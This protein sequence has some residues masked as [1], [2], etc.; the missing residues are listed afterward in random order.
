M[1]LRVPDARPAPASASTRSAPSGRPAPNRAHRNDIQGL[2][3]LAVGLVVCYHIWPNA[4][5]GGFIGV[6]VFFVISGYLIIGSLAREA[7]GGKIQLLRF[8]SRR[9]KRLLPA[10]GAVLVATM[11]ATVLILPQSRWQSVSRD[12][13]A[14]GLNIQNWNQAFFSTSYEGATA[15]VSPLQHF[16][17]L[18]VEEQFYLVAPVI[19]LS[20][21]WLARKRLRGGARTFKLLALGVLGSLTLASFTHSVLFSAASPDLA[22]FFTTTRVWELTLGGMVALAARPAGVR[23]ALSALLGWFGLLLVLGS[24][25]AFSTAMPFPGWIALFPVTGAIFLLLSGAS[26]QPRRGLSPAW[27]QSLGP[28]R[29][30]GDISYSLYLWHWPVI[31]FSVFLLGPNPGWL[32]GS[33]VIAASIALAAVSTRYI[34]QPVRNF[35]PGRSRSHGRRRAVTPG[36]GRI[37]ALG[38]LLTL[39]PIGLAAVPYQAMELKERSLTAELDLDTYPGAMALHGFGPRD[40]PDMPVRPDPAIAAADQPDAPEECRNSYDPAKVDYQDC[41]FG[42]GAAERSI[43]LVGDSHSA[44]Y[45]DSLSIV[46]R[47]SGYRLYVLSRNGCPF[48]IHPLQSDT[49]TY[50]NCSAQNEQTVQDILA[51]QPALVVTA[52]LSPAGYEDALGWRWSDESAA[53]DG[54]RGT[55]LPLQEAGIRIAVISDLPYPPFSV[56]ECVAAKSEDSCTFPAE[57]TPSPL[58]A[59]AESVDGAIS[60]DLRDYLCPDGVCRSVIG[61]VLVYRDNHVTGTFAKT[62]TIPLRQALGI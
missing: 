22:Y 19:L 37:F 21:A 9:I 8:Y 6:D 26:A 27:W 43:V 11:A 49:F 44:Q 15:S 61:N 52:A 4:L 17:S 36:Y 51:I 12:V 13:A 32:H 35:E 1:D 40:F 2:R 34:E 29:Y 28:M 45:L 50:T 30:L 48:S 56:P 55:L 54:F 59:A 33:A 3:A 18:A 39:L 47:E 16:W 53:I 23:P 20:C 46:A 42:D 58:A 10:A 7:A 57:H 41:V 62:L 31:V 25:A 5:P 60:V 14:S 24:A 38:A